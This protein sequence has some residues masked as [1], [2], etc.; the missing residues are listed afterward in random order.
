LANDNDLVFGDPYL[1]QTQKCKVAFTSQRPFEYLIVR[2]QGRKMPEP[3]A[4]FIWKLIILDKY[5]DFKK[6]YI[7][8]SLDYNPNNKAKD[9]GDA[10]L[11]LEKNSVSSK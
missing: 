11:L 8:L 5:V 7:T 6:L 4:N 1:S 3:I 2:A 10:F 9:L